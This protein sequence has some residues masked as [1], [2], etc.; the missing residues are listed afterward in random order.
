MSEINAKFQR[1]SPM[2]ASFETIIRVSNGPASDYNNLTNQP[3]INDVRL[4]G[5]RNLEEIGLNA[6][7]NIELEG[8]LK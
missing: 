4:I 1:A 8:L 2:D 3:K 5:N 6:I 7:T